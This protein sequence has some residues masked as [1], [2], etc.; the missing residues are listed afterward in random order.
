AFAATFLR[1]PSGRGVE[2]SSGL[3]YQARSRADLPQARRGQS[4]TGAPW[5][6][7]RARHL[8]WRAFDQAEISPFFFG[9]PFVRPAGGAVEPARSAGQTDA[10]RPDAYRK[11][12]QSGA[13]KDG[14]RPPPEAARSVLDRIAAPCGILSALA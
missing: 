4:G 9:Q 14:R 3:P 13:V 6:S 5:L 8:A 2:R 7:Q 10:L 11:A 1:S 12:T